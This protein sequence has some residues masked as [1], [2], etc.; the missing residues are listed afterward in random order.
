MLSVQRHELSVENDSTY[1]CSITPVPTAS[2]DL[3]ES[4]QP[5]VKSGE[6]VEVVTNLDR[7]AQA[8]LYA[9]RT[10]VPRRTMARGRDWESN[11]ALMTDTSI[12]R[13][14][15][16]AA[17]WLDWKNTAKPS[18]NTIKARRSDLVEIG[19]LLLDQPAEIPEGADPVSL[20]LSGLS[21]NDLDRDSVVRAFSVFATGH[22]PASIRRARSTWNG[23]CEWL[24]SYRDLL[25]RNPMSFVEAPSTVRWVPKPISELELGR[26]V[27]AAQQPSPTARN[28]WPEFE[29]AL[30][31]VF[32]GAG[33]RVSEATTLEVRSVVRSKTETPK[34]RVKGKGGKVRAVPFPSEFLAVVDRYL[35]S[36][37]ERFGRFKTTAPLFVRASSEPLTA[38]SVEYIVKGWF[39]RAGVVP[40][41]GALAHSLRH[42]YATLIIEQGGSVPELQRLLGHS[43]MSTTQ[44]YI[45]V[46]GSGVEGAAMVNPAR[47]LVAEQ[48]EAE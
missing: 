4:R 23:F 16:L 1:S 39:R 20:V 3:V 36:R 13:L 41:A 27:A 38:K 6:R 17:S 44:A 32:I 5:P 22:S 18:S 35:D 14:D 42:T 7:L 29:Q 21:V 40:P 2:V 12:L 28:P 15:R 8:L 26:V 47:Q 31:A 48:A 25:D 24:T 43:D 33:L 11:V 45:E 10:T 34:L 37:K 9:V 30:C 46:A 19:Q